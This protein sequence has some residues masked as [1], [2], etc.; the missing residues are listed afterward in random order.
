MLAALNGRG[1]VPSGVAADATAA[2]EPP[3]DPDEDDGRHRP[4][5]TREEVRWLRRQRRLPLDIRP[6]VIDL[7]AQF[8]VDRRTIQRALYGR[9]PYDF[10]DPAPR[11]GS[12][13]RDRGE[14][15]T[16][17]DA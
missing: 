16:W 10:G 15:K 11:R 9:P 8:G 14:G 5:L 7:A 4:K 17:R 3:L 2:E 12:P 1:Q 6:R 13:H